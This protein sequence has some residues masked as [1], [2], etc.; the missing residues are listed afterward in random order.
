L[1]GQSA[2]GAAV[3]FSRL[4]LFSSLSHGAVVTLFFGALAYICFGMLPRPRA[5]RGTL[6]TSVAAPPTADGYPAGTTGAQIG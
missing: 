2:T 1:L 3:V 4:N 6:A 5:V